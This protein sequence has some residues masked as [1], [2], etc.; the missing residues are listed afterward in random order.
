MKR[1]ESTTDERVRILEKAVANFADSLKKRDAELDEG[2]R[3]IMK[4]FKALKVFLARTIP[5][6]KQDFLEIQRKVK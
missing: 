5:E 4:E 3:D 1:N 6:F 2:L